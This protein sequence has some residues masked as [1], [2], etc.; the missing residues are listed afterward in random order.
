MTRPLNR[1]RSLEELEDDRWPVPS[2]DATRLVATAH[3]LRRKPIGELTVEDMRLL[4][5]QNE[6][7][8]YLLPLALEVLRLDPMAEGHMYEGDLLDAVLT[9]SPEIWSKSPELGRELRLIVSDLSDLTPN[10]KHEVE[11]FLTL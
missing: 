7:L 4:I 8:P 9:R 2:G 10:L 3:A 6:G 11:R 1:D 5:R